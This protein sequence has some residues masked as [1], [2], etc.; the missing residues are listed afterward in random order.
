MYLLHGLFHTL[1]V[2]RIVCAFFTWCLSCFVSSRIVCAFVPRFLSCFMSLENCL[3]ICH[4]IS[5]S[6]VSLEN[7][8]CICYMISF[9]LC[10][11]GELFTH[12]LHDD[13]QALVGLRINVLWI[14]YTWW[15]SRSFVVRVGELL[16]HL[17]HSFSLFNCQCELR[18]FLLAMLLLGLGICLRCVCR[19][20]YTG[21][22]WTHGG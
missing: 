14:W 11:F 13:F 20:V 12:L 3:W 10:Q 1:W 22:S 6:F 2:W 7:C 5:S 15:L 21:R 19:I 4:M 9:K 18:T 17:I 16:V 8:L